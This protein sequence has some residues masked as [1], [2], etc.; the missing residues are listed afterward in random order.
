MNPIKLAVG[1]RIFTIKFSEVSDDTPAYF[2]TKRKY[3][4]QVRPVMAN[5][6]D[7]RD[8]DILEKIRNQL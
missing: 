5:I 3:M 8:L 1:A 7:D 2:A 4:C 6:S